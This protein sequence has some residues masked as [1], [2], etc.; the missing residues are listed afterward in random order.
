[1]VTTDRS[2]ETISSNLTAGFLY[3]FQVFA[4]GLDGS[5]SD[6]GVLIDGTCKKFMLDLTDADCKIQDYWGCCEQTITAP[7]VGLVHPSDV[8]WHHMNW[9]AEILTLNMVLVHR[10]LLVWMA[11]LLEVVIFQYLLFRVFRWFWLWDLQVWLYLGIRRKVRYNV[12][13]HYQNV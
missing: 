5:E 6:P 8:W 4:V 3:E 2:S 12:F 13:L 7:K 9:L 10:L 11:F 1:M